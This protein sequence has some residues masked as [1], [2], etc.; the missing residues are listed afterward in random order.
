MPFSS[1][2]EKPALPG[3]IT[4]TQG[5]ITTMKKIAG[6][7]T[8]YEWLERQFGSKLLVKYHTFAKMVDLGELPEEIIYQRKRN[9]MRYFERKNLREWARENIV[10]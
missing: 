1:D 5:M 2:K 9:A 8:A 4:R 6:T 10:R 7:K 3:I